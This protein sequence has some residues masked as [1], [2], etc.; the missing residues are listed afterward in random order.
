MLIRIDVDFGD[1]EFVISRCDR[2]ERSDLS[3][4]SVALA[5]G[6]CA[7]RMIATL[8][9]GGTTPID[10]MVDMFRDATLEAARISVVG[11]DHRVEGSD[12]HDR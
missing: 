10:T 2:Y 12:A 8:M 9:A 6:E 4:E 5:L 3:S 7:G 1:R 11:D